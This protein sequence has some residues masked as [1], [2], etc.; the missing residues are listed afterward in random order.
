LTND[1]G[2]PFLMGHDT[3]PSVAFLKLVDGWLSRGSVPA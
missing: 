3:P 1:K 2:A